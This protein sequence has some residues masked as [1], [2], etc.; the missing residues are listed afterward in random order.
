VRSIVPPPFI[1]Y[2]FLYKVCPTPSKVSRWP[3]PQHPLTLRPRVCL[4]FEGTPPPFSN[5]TPQRV[6]PF[7]VQSISTLLHFFFPL[8]LQRR[9]VRRLVRPSAAPSMTLRL[10][11]KVGN[12]LSYFWK[13]LGAWRE[14]LPFTYPSPFFFPVLKLSRARPFLMIVRFFQLFSLLLGTPQRPTP[15]PLHLRFFLHFAQPYYPLLTFI[16][17]RNPKSKILL[18]S[19]RMSF[20]P[21]HL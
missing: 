18:L 21:P 20:V 5:M 14:P 17:Y 7:S 12:H 1:P 9:I 2:P 15:S 13:L 10:L 3:F 11:L 8:Q 6:C 19:D 16:C 4:P